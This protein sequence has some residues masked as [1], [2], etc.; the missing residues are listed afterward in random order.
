MQLQ[1]TQLQ[2]AIYNCMLAHLADS[3][4]DRQDCNASAKHHAALV[5]IWTTY[6]MPCESLLIPKGLI[7]WYQE[8]ATQDPTIRF[9]SRAFDFSVRGTNKLIRAYLSPFAFIAACWQHEPFSKS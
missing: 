8:A 1:K 7:R 6:S 9:G 2:A 4:F 5:L 3:L